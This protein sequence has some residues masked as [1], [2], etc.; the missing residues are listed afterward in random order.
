MII[1][2]NFRFLLQKHYMLKKNTLPNKKY[3]LV[4]YELLLGKETSFYGTLL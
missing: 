4:K 1:L 3:R 2:Q